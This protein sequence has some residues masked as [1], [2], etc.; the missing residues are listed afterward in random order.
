M[1]PP[2]YIL[3][4]SVAAFVQGTVGFAFA[5]LTVPLLSLVLAPGAATALGATVGLV[6]VITGVVMHRDEIQWRGMLAL[7]AAAVIFIP[8]G[9]LFVARAPESVVLSILALITLSVGIDS[10]LRL[11]PHRRHAAEP[12]TAETAPKRPSK[13]RRSR[14]LAALAAAMSGTMAGAFATPGPPMVAYLYATT[15]DRRLAKANL[16]AFFILTSALTVVTQ[17]SVGNL[18]IEML[19]YALIATLPVAASTALGVYIS[20]SLDTLRLRIA[21]DLALLALGLA[22]IVRAWG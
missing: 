21:T 9:A 20:R 3:L 2:I 14:A 4:I 11:L 17:A 10:L 5:L 1:I 15:P 19:P 7:T 6:V 18:T 22:L 16:Q 8:V 12:A 13:K